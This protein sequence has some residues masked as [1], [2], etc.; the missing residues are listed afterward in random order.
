M[1]HAAGVKPISIWK[2]AYAADPAE[3]SP[4][5][6]NANVNATKKPLQLMMMR[7]R[8]AIRSRAIILNA[9]NNCEK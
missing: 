1:S 6:P 8:I 3:V 7:I 2:S 4:L 9:I 5:S